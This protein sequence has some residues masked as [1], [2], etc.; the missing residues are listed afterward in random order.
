MQQNVC[1]ICGRFCDWQH[2]HTVEK[3]GELFQQLAEEHQGVW[4]PVP[5]TL[6]LDAAPEEE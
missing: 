4:K 2:A 6:P 5:A 1:P 3:A